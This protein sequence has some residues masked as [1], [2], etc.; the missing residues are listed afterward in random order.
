VKVIITSS[1]ADC[2]SGVITGASFSGSMKI[3]KSPDVGVVPSVTDTDIATAPNSS[4]TG[5]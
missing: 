1:V 5:V 4:T 3:W 2:S